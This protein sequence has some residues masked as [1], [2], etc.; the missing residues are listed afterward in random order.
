MD[1]RDSLRIL[2]WSTLATG[3][4]A[5]ACKPSDKKQTIQ[6]AA[7]GDSTTSINRM[8]EETAAYNKVVAEKFLTEHE[9]ATIAILSDILFLVTQFQVAPQ[10]PRCQILLNLL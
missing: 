9:L 10:T 2:A 3:V 7:K 6:S 4:L 5:E 8:P 1:R